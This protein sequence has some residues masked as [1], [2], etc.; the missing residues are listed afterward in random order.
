MSDADVRALVTY[1]RSLPPV[2]FQAPQNA[3]P[4][5]KAPAPYLSVVNP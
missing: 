4:N 1:L 3:G 5:E 2:R